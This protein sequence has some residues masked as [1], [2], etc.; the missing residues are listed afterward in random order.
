MLAGQCTRGQGPV[1]LCARLLCPCSLAA[2]VWREEVTGVEE[3]RE[4]KERDGW[5]RHHCDVDD[6]GQ[7]LLARVYLFPF[8]P[9]PRAPWAS[10]AVPRTSGGCVSASLL[11]RCTLIRRACTCHPVHARPHILSK[12][13]LASPSP[14]SSHSLW[15]HTSAAMSPT[16]HR[17]PSILP[18]AAQRWLI[19]LDCSAHTALQSTYYVLHVDNYRHYRA[20]LVVH[21]A[22]PVSVVNL[23]V[24]EPSKVLTENQIPEAGMCCGANPD[25][26]CWALLPLRVRRS[27]SWLSFAFV[28]RGCFPATLARCVGDRLGAVMQEK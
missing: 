22:P 19:Y 5:S 11:H 6:T 3:S 2:A 15:L 9:R 27:G 17:S 26:R 21:I 10:V 8:P 23:D 13:R 24:L 1:L 14:L 16:H 25:G 18:T 12:L 4:R 28:H 7:L 20:V